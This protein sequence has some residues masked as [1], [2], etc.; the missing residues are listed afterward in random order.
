MDEKSSTIT[1][2]LLLQ[3]IKVLSE[4]TDELHKLR[5]E[6]EQLRDEKRNLIRDVACMSKGIKEFKD[7]FEPYLVEAVEKQK[8]WQGWRRDWFKMTIG[9]AIICAGG[10]AMYVVGEI[11]I[12]WISQK[13]AVK[14]HK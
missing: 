12:T 9:A 11:A 13:L 6:V 2:P 3:F 1:Q 5:A 4:N 10:F 8:L 7:K 14:L